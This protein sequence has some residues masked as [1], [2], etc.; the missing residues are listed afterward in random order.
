MTNCECSSGEYK[1]VPDNTDYTGGGVGH[2]ITRWPGWVD[3]DARY[4]VQ[5]DIIP[6]PISPVHFQQWPGMQYQLSN[7]W[8][9]T[10]YGQKTPYDDYLRMLYSSISSPGA[11]RPLPGEGKQPTANSLVSQKTLQQQVIFNNEPLVTAGAGGLNPGVS[12]GKRSY[13]G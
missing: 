11:P 12:L 13:Y 9:F 4:S 10:N 8:Q 1:Q 2:P 7:G 5:T 6:I 3:N